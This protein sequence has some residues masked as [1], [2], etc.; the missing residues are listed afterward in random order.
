MAIIVALIGALGLVFHSC[1][2]N[3]FADSPNDGEQPPVVDSPGDPPQV[4]SPPPTSPAPPVISDASVPHVLLIDNSGSMGYCPDFPSC[5]LNLNPTRLDEARKVVIDL[6]SKGLFDSIPLA[7]V[8]Y[9]DY[10]RAGEP[11]EDAADSQIQRLAIGP[12]DRG[13]IISALEAIEANDYGC[14]PTGNSML[15]VRAKYFT[16]QNGDSK[17]VVHLVTDGEANCDKDPDQIREEEALKFL[18]AND[19]EVRYVLSGYKLSSSRVQKFT[20]LQSDYPTLF[21]FAGNANN[22]QQLLETINRSFYVSEDGRLPLKKFAYSSY[23]NGVPVY[24]SPSTS[25]DISKRLENNTVVYVNDEVLSSLSSSR[26][27]VGHSLVPDSYDG[28]WS[29]SVDGGWIPSFFLLDEQTPPS[30]AT[31]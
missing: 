9:G 4:T 22:E 10:F 20:K 29:Q 19:V 30:T 24:L 7:V 15:W 6:I 11:E 26:I 31:D 8:E 16:D 21:S 13:T 14:T 1:G 25:S 28:G 3:F 2:T 5:D 23:G 12:H 27:E 17:G 18:L